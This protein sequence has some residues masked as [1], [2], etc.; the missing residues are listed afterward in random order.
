[1]LKSINNLHKSD[2]LILCLFILLLLDL[3]TLLVSTFTSFEATSSNNLTPI[4]IISRFSFDTSFEL[5]FKIDHP[6]LVVPKSKL[7][8]ILGFSK[9]SIIVL[10]LYI[11]I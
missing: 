1:M 4:S 6:T 2:F 5:I 7:I 11:F 3:A 9:F 8:A 10:K